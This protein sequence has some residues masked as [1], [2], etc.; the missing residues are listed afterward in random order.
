MKFIIDT[1]AGSKGTWFSSSRSNY[2]FQ[3]QPL[4]AAIERSITQVRLRCDEPITMDIFLVHKLEDVIKQ[5]HHKKRKAS[6]V[7][8]TR[9]VVMKECSPRCPAGSDSLSEEIVTKLFLQ[10]VETRNEDICC[11]LL[12]L[13]SM[14]CI[15]LH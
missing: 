9:A 3:K 5:L 11:I 6:K 4:E 8:S 13:P 12:H 2:G 10:A 1:I 14:L 7:N 15:G